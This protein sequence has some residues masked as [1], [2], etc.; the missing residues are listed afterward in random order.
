MLS[1]LF[2]YRPYTV[3]AVH[4]FRNSAIDDKRRLELRIAQLEEELEEEQGNVEQVNDKLRK[5]LLQVFQASIRLYRTN[6]ASRIINNCLTAV[7][8]LAYTGIVDS[9]YYR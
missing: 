3:Y 4:S 8:L 1:V 6:L 7:L 9:I 2:N 5:A